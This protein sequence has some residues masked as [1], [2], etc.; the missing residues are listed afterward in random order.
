MGGIFNGITGNDLWGYIQDLLTSGIVP[1]P[2]TTGLP[3]LP[4]IP[5][6]PVWAPLYGDPSF[7]VP[8]IPILLN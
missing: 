3:T 1:I 5:T 7:P 6:G 8:D 2:P 4:P